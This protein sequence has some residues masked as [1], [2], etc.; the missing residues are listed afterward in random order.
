M[1]STGDVMEWYIEFIFKTI[2][3]I[4]KYFSVWFSTEL[5]FQTLLASMS[6]RGIP[7]RIVFQKKGKVTV[8]DRPTRSDDVH[9]T[10]FDGIKCLLLGSL[11]V[12]F[13]FGVTSESIVEFAGNPYPKRL[14]RDSKFY[15]HPAETHVGCLLARI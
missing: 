6:F 13:E 5:A 7:R 9:G 10:N 8:V 2:F 4:H 11:S 14:P 1:I 3:A 15:Q 12:R